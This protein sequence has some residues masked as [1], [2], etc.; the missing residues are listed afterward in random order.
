MVGLETAAAVAFSELGLPVELLLALMSW[1][2]A[3]IA[4]LSGTHGGPIAP[5]AAANICVIDPSRHWR[6][7]AGALASRSH[8]TPF[9]GRELTAKVRHTIF[10]GEPVVIAEEAQR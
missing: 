4:G 7:V 3:A 1:Q 9:A 5:G 2:P 8:N 6:V 10:A